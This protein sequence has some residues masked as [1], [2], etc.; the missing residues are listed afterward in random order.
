ML[1]L[2]LEALPRGLLLEVSRMSPF[3]AQHVERGTHNGRD[4]VLRAA[5][6]VDTARVSP[7]DPVDQNVSQ[8]VSRAAAR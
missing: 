8:T 5:D 7:V 4:P 6:T 2:A 1:E 3:T